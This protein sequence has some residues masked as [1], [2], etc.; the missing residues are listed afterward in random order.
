M[1]VDGI[2][3]HCDLALVVG[4]D[5]TMLGIGRQLARYQVP[6]IGINSG[7]L[8]FITDI[9]FEQ[10]K[11]TLA[12]M[13]AGHYEV[14]DR[15]LMRARVMRDGHCVFEAEAMN[16]VVVNRGATSGHGGAAG[17]GRRALCGQPA[18][19]RADHRLAHGFHRLRHVGRRAA[20]A[21]LDRRVGDGADCAPYP[22]K[23]ADSPR[24]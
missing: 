21:P 16:D 24:R 7:R 14:D 8:G 13:L 2:G 5:G 11:T 15:A 9:R 20:V 4:G 18:G 22:I 12:P 17:G 10:Y 23:S 19:G 6:L 1:D 3:T